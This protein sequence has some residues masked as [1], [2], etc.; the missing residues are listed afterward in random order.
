MKDEQ[1][2]NIQLVSCDLNGTLVHQHTM[3][4]MIRVYFPQMPER[5]EKAKAAAL[6]ALEI[7]N[8]LAEAHCAI[9]VVKMT[10]EYDWRAANESFNR[11]VEINQGLSRT[12]Y[13]YS[14]YLIAIGLLDE[15]IRELKLALELDPLST[16]II[17][18]IGMAFT[19]N[20]QYNKS[21]EYLNRALEMTPNDPF[22][23]AE[24]GFAYAKKG[25]YE[26]A[27][28]TLQEG[29]KVFDKSPILMSAL[30]YAYGVA[31]KNAEAQE[32]VNGLIEISNKSYF[33]PQFISKVYAGMGDVDRAI[34]WLEKAYEIRDPMLYIIKSIHHMTICTQIKDSLLY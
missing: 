34:E 26:K 7:D 18:L 5:Y 11:I 23:L 8:L 19:W 33:P 2:G 17:S 10:Y 4:D 6:K 20:H 21:I 32:V 28:S 13:Y 3:M 12:H 15:A 9:G 25:E 24:L 30:G 27:I 16:R 1:P 29:A 31:G 22:S 14:H